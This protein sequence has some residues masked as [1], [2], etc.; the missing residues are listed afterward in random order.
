ME[1]AEP[2]LGLLQ[3]AHGFGSSDRSEE[4]VDAGVGGMDLVG[5]K[6]VE[7]VLVPVLLFVSQ[8]SVRWSLM[9]V[10]VGGWD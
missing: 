6:A 10:G 2:E 8:V 1:N 4:V 3:L 9:G 7:D 5:E